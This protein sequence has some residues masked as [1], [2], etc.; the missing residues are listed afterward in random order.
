M[1]PKRIYASVFVLVFSHSL[2]KNCVFVFLFNCGQRRRHFW[3]FMPWCFIYFYSR[4]VLWLW[5]IAGHINWASVAVYKALIAASNNGLPR[6]P[7]NSP[8]SL[9]SQFMSA[10]LLHLN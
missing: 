4:F 6:R 5:A 3:N 9:F 10:L 8:P 2:P 7:K 1:R